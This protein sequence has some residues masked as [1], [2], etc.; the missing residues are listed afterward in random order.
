[1]SI[2]GGNQGTPGLC[3]CLVYPSAADQNAQARSTSD[4]LITT[5]PIL[6]MDQA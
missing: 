1:M 4:T 5:A 3:G 6:S 2:I